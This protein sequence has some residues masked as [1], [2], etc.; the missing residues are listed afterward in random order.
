MVL[1]L[2]SF[3]KDGPA[4]ADGS[5]HYDCLLTNQRTIAADALPQLESI[6]SNMVCSFN[7]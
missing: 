5:F 7:L 2:F 4:K 1:T 3:S 6:V